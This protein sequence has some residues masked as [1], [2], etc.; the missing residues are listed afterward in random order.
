M[1]KAM[2]C[3]IGV[4]IGLLTMCFVGMAFSFDGV[5]FATDLPAKQ[6]PT[7]IIDYGRV[8]V[9]E[10]YTEKDCRFVL[11]YNGKRQ[12]LVADISSL[13]KVRGK[14][15]KRPAKARKE[16]VDFGQK[17][18]LTLSEAMSYAFPEV[19]AA[20]D[21]MAKE[22]YVAP[23]DAFVSTTKNSGKITINEGKTGTE[24]DKDKIYKNLYEQI[25]IDKDIYN[26]DIITKSIYYNIDSN[27]LKDVCHLKSTYSISYASSSP[28]RKNNIRMALSSFDGVCI[29]PG[30]SLS[31]NESTG[32]RSEQR[33]YKK[34][35]IIKNGIFTDEYGGGVCQ[36]STTLYNAAILADMEVV[37]VHPHSLPVSYI[38]PCF[39]AMVSGGSSDL[40]IKNTTG[41]DIYICTRCDED[42]CLVSIYGCKNNYQIVRKSE[43]IEDLLQIDTFITD[44]AEAF[45][46]QP[47]KQGESLVINEGKSGYKA[48]GWLEYYKDGVLVKTKRIRA[49]T[50]LPT[51]R[52]VLVGAE[53]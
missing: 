51:K 42:S 38:Q 53:Q 45:N 22:V 21:N 26:I 17:V 19:E 18:G 46:R 2:L 31:F 41:K 33:G 3:L 11:N 40:V 12:E 10:P 25:G 47:L 6:L 4:I 1:K 5:A 36:A 27:T 15:V 50:Y 13:S 34:A 32:P 39:D 7:D 29:R 20:L 49:N 43:K 23:Q 37:E 28:E 16:I 52:V 35:K 9:S 44:D 8:E 14:V 24:I 30:Q 48:I